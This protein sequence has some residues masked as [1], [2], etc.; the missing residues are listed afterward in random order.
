MKSED[1]RRIEYKRTFSSAEGKAVLSDL[2]HY[3]NIGLALPVNSDPVLVY[4]V[5]CMRRVFWHIHALVNA[6]PEPRRVAPKFDFQ[7]GNPLGFT[8]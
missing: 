7:N 2:A 3:C 1:Q 6:R 8:E 4:G 5:E